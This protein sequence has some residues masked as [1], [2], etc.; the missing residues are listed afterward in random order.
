M[1]PCFG[2][3]ALLGITSAGNVGAGVIHDGPTGGPILVLLSV[4][5]F[6][7][8]V[9]LLPPRSVVSF[10]SCLRSS[11]ILAFRYHLC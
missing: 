9:S 7:K 11:P 10:Y 3:H 1:Y 2:V 8:E 4:Q 5:A 6:E